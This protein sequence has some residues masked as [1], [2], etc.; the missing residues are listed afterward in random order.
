MRWEFIMTLASQELWEGRKVR[1]QNHSEEATPKL[2]PRDR[3]NLRI[4]F[5]GNHGMC[6]AHGKG[7]SINGKHSLL[8]SVAQRWKMNTLEVSYWLVT[9][10][11]AMCPD[12]SI[13]VSKSSKD[14]LKRSVFHAEVR[15]EACREVYREERK[16]I[17][18]ERENGKNKYL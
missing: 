10:M 6:R 7:C 14:S 9:C 15:S 17:H 1:Q 12:L 3:K 4:S 18:R 2:K 11:C 5:I 16:G 8:F 13:L